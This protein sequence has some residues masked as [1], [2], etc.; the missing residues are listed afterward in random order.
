MIRSVAH[1]AFVA[2]ALAAALVA[3]GCASKDEEMALM[4]DNE[5]LYALS[6]RDIA[7]RKFARAERRLGNAGLV[8]PLSPELQPK[9]QLA[10]A[11]TFFFQGGVKIVDAQVRYEQFL[12]FYRDHPLATRARYM[13]GL[14]LFEQAESPDNDQEF[15]RRALEHFLVM[16]SELDESSPYF[17]PV[18]QMVVRAQNRLAEHEWQVANFYLD[19]N[20]YLGAIRRFETLIDEYPQATRREE[21]LFRLAESYLA[22]GDL[23][24]ADFA[25]DRLEAI[26]PLGDFEDQARELR[27]QMSRSTGGTG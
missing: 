23:A 8:T 17:L 21:A 9:V 27:E 11:D 20:R 16:S 25:L 22:V 6:E 14:C 4:S 13:I 19:K 24:Q 26:Y 3:S 1:P 2:M 15:A 7:T 5:L 18:Q 12:T 10:L